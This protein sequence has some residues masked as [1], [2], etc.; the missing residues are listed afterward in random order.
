[1]KTPK[2]SVVVLNYNGLEYL[3]NCFDSL[4]QTNYPNFE[5]IM[6]DNRSTDQSVSYTKKFYPWVKIIDSGSNSGW[7][8]GNNI[9][10]KKA[11]GKYIVLL[12][13]DTICEPDWLS[14][15][16]DI[17]ESDKKIA[18][19][20]ALEW[21]LRGEVSKVAQN[22][23]PYKIEEVATA[24]GA[25]MMVK[26]EVFEKIGLFE[27]KYF[28]YW[29]D[30]EFNYRAIL[31]GYKVMINY[32]S[33]VHHVFGGYTGKRESERWI[34]EKV[35]NRLHLHLKIMNIFYLLYFFT[36][37]ICKMLFHFLKLPYSIFNGNPNV[38]RAYFKAW[39]WFIKN[40]KF[41]MK[42]R[43]EF[44][45]KFRQRRDIHLISMILKTWRIKR[46][47]FYYFYKIS[48]KN[49]INQPQLKF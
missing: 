27:E 36:S 14:K 41:T 34:Y 4:K 35:K 16:I 22:K 47:L 3:K 32:N 46:V 28:I 11:N 26:R 48:K 13:N 33:V 39:T 12:N 10:I 45:K 20:G 19:V 2:V 40:F 37:E 49:K 15:L 18:V 8:V 31:T 9:G 21:P 30:T 44:K 1:M 7:A 25:A 23:F 42:E 38:L 17:A 5:V 24:S 6:V 29:E 43:V